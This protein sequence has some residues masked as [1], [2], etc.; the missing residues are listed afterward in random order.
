MRCVGPRLTRGRTCACTR[1]GAPRSPTSKPSTCPIAR[2]A[3]SGR[4]SA[5]SRRGSARRR[6]PRTRCAAVSTSNSAPAPGS[7]AS[8]DV[9]DHADHAGCS[10]RT[11]TRAMSSARSA[12]RRDWRRTT[13]DGSASSECAGPS[14]A[15][16]ARRAPTLRRSR[17]SSSSSSAARACPR[18]PTRS[19]PS[20]CRNRSSS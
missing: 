20:T 1:S 17:I 5:T 3:P 12:P 2:R 11:P 13:R 6:R 10:R 19:S 9:Q 8:A 18:S 14:D 4:S 16:T 7:S 15:R